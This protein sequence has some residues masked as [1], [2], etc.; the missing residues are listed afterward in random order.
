MSDEII[1]IELDD[2]LDLHPFHPKDVKIV[3]KE[4][5]DM[6]IEKGIT[7]V[8]IIHGKGRSTIKGIVLKELEKNDKVISFKDDAGNWGASTA[9][10]KPEKH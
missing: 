10:L 4:F 6:A 9:V 8:R 5:I 2:E 3:L 1:N 7:E